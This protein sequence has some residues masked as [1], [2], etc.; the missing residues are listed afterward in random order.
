M[1]ET[2]TAEICEAACRSATETS[3]DRTAAASPGASMSIDGFMQRLDSWNQMAAGRRS[4][5]SV[6]SAP[7]LVIDQSVGAGE[8]LLLCAEYAQ[9]RRVLI[10]DLSVAKAEVERLCALLEAHKARERDVVRSE[11]RQL[12]KRF[13]LKV[14]DLYPEAMALDQSVVQSP[15]EQ[16]SNIEG[17]VAKNS[18]K[19]ECGQTWSGRGRYPRWLKQALEEGRSL[20]E[21]TT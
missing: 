10:R 11:V 3:A 19:N 15:C 1:Q 12:I 6:E 21:F 5:P 17:S 7:K 13:A 16:Q 20:D 8:P 9:E 2:S 4:D 18:Y 14:S